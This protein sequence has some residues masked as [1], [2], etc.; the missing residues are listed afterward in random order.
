MAAKYY[1]QSGDRM[2]L[3]P[4]ISYG[5]AVPCC[6]MAAIIVEKKG[7]KLGLRIGGYFTGIGKPN[8]TTKLDIDILL[9]NLTNFMI[10]KY[11]KNVKN[12]YCFIGLYNINL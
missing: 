9:R 2:D 12:V 11:V 1:E 5:L 8:Q 4:T 7:L 6:F 3:I 10:R